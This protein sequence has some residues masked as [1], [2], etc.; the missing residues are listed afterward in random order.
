MRPTD[1][2]WRKLFGV[3]LYALANAR[4]GQRLVLALRAL[5]SVVV[6]CPVRP[7]R[8]RG[9]ILFVNTTAR[10]DYRDVIVS[11]YEACRQSKILWE[12]AYRFG[13]NIEG[14]GV[15]CRQLKE[16]GAFRRFT[17]GDLLGSIALFAA[18]VKCVQFGV[19]AD[20]L[21]Y[22]AVVVAADMQLLES[23][24]IQRSNHA[25]LPTATCQ[26]GL[27]TD[28]GSQ[29]RHDNINIINYL[30]CCSR[31][32]MAWGVRTK[33]LM[34]K[35]TDTECVVVGNPAL[36]DVSRRLAQRYF[37]VL[38]DSDLRFRSYNQRLLKIAAEVSRRSGMAFFVRFHPDNDPASYGSYQRENQQSPLLEAAFAIGHLTSQIYAS[39]QSGVPVYRLVSSE[40]NHEIGAEFLF[41]DADDLLAKNIP[42]AAFVDLGRSFIECVGASSAERCASF[43]DHLIARPSGCDGAMSPPNEF[44]DNGL[45]RN[46]RSACASI[47]GAGDG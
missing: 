26:H 33:G 32:F 1:L 4:F 21:R 3:P 31:Y 42:H 8:S 18:W 9:E 24:L 7:N 23:Y 30:N 29:D 28:N 13:L 43:F 11:S 35:Y 12:V 15:A 2:D 34:E 16:F 17:D 40:P 46:D 22:R 45:D 47:G 41:V 25:G 44:E 6:R 5:V 14:I 36:P 38:T 20:G 19:I 27:Y 39:M 10:K 37:Y